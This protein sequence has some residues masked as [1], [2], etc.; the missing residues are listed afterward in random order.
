MPAFND[1]ITA[2]QLQ[3]FYCGQLKYAFNSNA[4]HPSVQPFSQSYLFQEAAGYGAPALPEPALE[5]YH[6]QCSDALAVPPHW[7]SD[8]WNGDLAFTAPSPTTSSSHLPASHPDS[9]S[10]SSTPP[11]TGP[12][13]NKPNKPG[14]IPRPSNAFLLFR[15]YFIQT[16]PTQ[17]FSNGKRLNQNEIS[18]MAGKAWRA[19]SKEERQLWSDKGE[20]EKRLHKLKYPDYVYEPKTRANGR[21]PRKDRKAA[22]ATGSS[23][24]GG[25][26]AYTSPASSSSSL[27]PSPRLP[28]LGRPFHPD[29][30]FPMVPNPN[31]AYH[32]RKGSNNNSRFEFEGGAVLPVQAPAYQDPTPLEST[33]D[34]TQALATPMAV[35]EP[36]P[37]P[38]LDLLDTPHPA[39]EFDLGPYSPL[40]IYRILESS[41]I[42]YV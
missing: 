26:S 8:T 7:A 13:R 29:L 11:S 40:D 22:R 2:Q 36:D 20:E 23:S 42:L 37:V 21:K 10:A 33:A 41:G 28:V 31:P 4:M 18:R 1:P 35:Q 24:D 3:Q 16:N 19:L 6:I 17:I 30:D 27:S 15:T 34:P 38:V 14:H 25:S 39:A 12:I 5:P 32:K 9:S